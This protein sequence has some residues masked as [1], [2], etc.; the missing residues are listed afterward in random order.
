MKHLGWSTAFGLVLVM[1]ACSKSPAPDGHGL[2]TEKSRQS[3]L[4]RSSIEFVE[5]KTEIV[6][7]ETLFDGVIEAVNQS[8]VSAQTHG[9]IEELPFDVGDYVAKGSL[10]A[11]ITDTQQQAGLESAKAAKKLSRV[12]FEDAEKNYHRVDEIFKKG[13][14][15]QADYDQAKTEY[16]AALANVKVAESLLTQA[17]ETLGYTAIKAPYSGIV[18]SRAREMGETVA[19]GSEIMTGLSLEHLRAVV[20]IS[21]Q[22]IGPLR[23]H[24]QARILLPNGKSVQAE[25]IRIPPG[26][27]PEVHTFRILLS[28]PQGTHGF[29][30]GTLVK[31]AFVSGEE[32]RLLV[33][34]ES[35]AFRGEVTGVYLVNEKQAMEFRYLRVG[36]R[37]ADNQ[38]SVLAGLKSGEHIA[39]DPVV[40]AKV[41]RQAF[42]ASDQSAR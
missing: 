19:P 16:R 42:Q 34:G 17:E 39:R 15:A 29:F 10:I 38:Y 7:T 2:S 27:D 32:E 31:V 5:V 4:S 30:P 33:P 41:Y 24:K 36:A 23:Q 20:D 11:R 14:V 9:R 21:P 13:L 40:A 37:H 1:M 18:V 35:L 6:A 3:L 26:A 25:Q 28:L 8:T 12:R 22:H